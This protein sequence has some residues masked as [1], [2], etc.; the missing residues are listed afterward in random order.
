M[1]AAVSQGAD[2]LLQNPSQNTARFG[3]VLQPYNPVGLT[4]KQCDT[5]V[6]R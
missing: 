4:V 3:D 6:M 2:K 1:T 5:V